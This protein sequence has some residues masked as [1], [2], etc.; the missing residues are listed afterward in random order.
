MDEISVEEG[1]SR[2]LTSLLTDR[3]ALLAGAGLS[4]AAPSSLPSAAA[5]AHS[6]KQKYD[7]MFCPPEAPLSTDIEEQTQY[8]FERGQLATVYFRTLIDQDAFAGPPNAGHY[9]IADLLLVRAVQTAMTTNVDTMIETAGQM[10]FGQVASAIDGISV[11]A[12]PP[13]T[14]PLLKLHGCRS[15]DPT[16]MVWAPGQLGVA[17]VAQRIESSRNWLHGRLTDRDLL[18]I[19]FSTDWEYLN[20]L[21]AATLGAA[22]PAS[23]LVVDP[24]LG[25]VFA[26]KAPELFALGQRAGVNFRYVQASG[27]DFL[28]SLRL[29][30]SKSFVR[31][32]LAGGVDL[33]QQHCGVAPDP[34]WAE[35]PDLSNDALWRVRRDL[36][37]RLPNRPALDRSPAAGPLLGFTVLQLRARG[38][39]AEGHHW[40]M[41][42]R[43]IRVV[44]AE[45][46]PLHQMAAAFSRESSAPIAP[47]IV[48]AV[49]AEDF[50][51]QANY[52]RSEATATI[53]RGAPSRW[54]TRQDA[55]QEFGL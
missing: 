9:C 19:G 12:F 5:L 47:D 53:A 50:G 25:E 52:V 48:V 3:L 37:G 46:K 15:I 1:V 45:G 26:Q 21:L 41:N 35:A 17:P 43:R 42:G 7:P 28:D 4:M 11:A 16:N 27:A 23:V 2:A 18:I 22:N 6:A 24:A 30:F 51:L 36:E 54:V 38:A 32:V 29:S 44:C 34:A 8:F 13:D 10:L 49:G 33:F 39:T 40:L 55:V 20:E 31:R 14:S